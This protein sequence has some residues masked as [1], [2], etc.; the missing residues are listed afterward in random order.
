MVAL[1]LLAL[2]MNACGDGESPGDRRDASSSLW[3]ASEPS[4]EVTP[5]RL[6]D[7][8][9][10][11]VDELWV[12]AAR[13][14]GSGTGVLMERLP[15]ATLP[16]RAEVTLVVRGLWPESDVAIGEAIDHCA[17]S[18]RQLVLDM[19]TRGLEVRGFHLDL[20][21]ESLESLEDYGHFVARLRKRVRRQGRLSAKVEL[22][23]LRESKTVRPLLGGVDVAV[24]PLYG[25][26]LSDPDRR[27]EWSLDG[28]AEGAAEFDE[29][30]VPFLVEASLQGRAQRLD[31]SGQVVEELAGLPI[32]SLLASELSVEPLF[33]FAGGLRQ[34]FEAVATSR[35]QI[36]TMTL[37]PRDRLRVFRPTAYDLARLAD[38]L[39]SLDLPHYRG[40]VLRRWPRAGESLTLAPEQVV[41][42][43]G[44]AALEPEL[45]L[46]VER[47][48]SD[49]VRV[50]IENRGP[51]PTALAV[52]NHN[53]VE[54][55]LE[56]ARLG[57]VDVGDFKR[58][59]LENSSRAEGD[60]RA[61]R[62]ADVLRLFYPG[63]EPGARVASGSIGFRGTGGSPA[64]RVGARF[65]L[66]GGTTLELP[67]RDASEL[68]RTRDS[69]RPASESTGPVDGES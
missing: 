27:E 57:R 51:V 4:P 61:L 13:L 32:D 16:A 52:V 56:R 34:E 30:R 54:I 15:S 48:S 49:R 18:L 53:Y 7:L 36:G 66:P 24:V 8:R 20:D 23:W 19:E 69:D 63:L 40:L 67:L 43:L 31:Q 25:H 41:L 46:T 14:G 64:V 22:Q 11:G 68:V 55:R 50:T 21:L 38:E 10:S 47:L 2:C 28:A 17:D 9:G 5:S 39:D 37:E 44:G 35:P 6:A 26:P 45:A 12:E 29:I 3:V 58:M 59:E 60:M 1:L 62:H 42:A 65:F 33:D